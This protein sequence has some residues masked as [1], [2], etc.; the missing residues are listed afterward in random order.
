MR[1]HGILAIIAATA[2][3]ASSGL[4]AHAASGGSTSLTITAGTR[5]VT[6]AAPGNFTATL[7]GSD[8]TVNSTLS[9]YS[10]I[11]ATGT[12]SGWNITFQATQFACAYNAVTNPNCPQVGG[13]TF[14]AGSLIIAPPT[15]SAAAGTNP[16]TNPRA[17]APAIS[18]IANTAVDSSAAVKVAS[19]AVNK[20]MGSY[21]FIPGAVGTGQISLA[22]P[23]SAYAATY[24]STLTVSI[25]SG[26]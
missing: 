4:A 20:G 19:A 25:N 11:D 1:K 21:N 12:G 2:L 6:G 13:D 24:N 22:V 5:S 26:P 15:V 23:S 3:L 18:I 17:A 9:N 10:A 14:A 8:Q 16:G 7:T